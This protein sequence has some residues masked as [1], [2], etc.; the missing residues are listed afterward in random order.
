MWPP[1]RDTD[2]FGVRFEICEG[3]KRVAFFKITKMHM[4]KKLIQPLMPDMT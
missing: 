2:I 4:L 3:G 1:F